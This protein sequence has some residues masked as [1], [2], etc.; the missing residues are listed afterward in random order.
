MSRKQKFA[1][2]EPLYLQL[3]GQ[4]GFAQ[5]LDRRVKIAV[6]L[7][8]PLDLPDEGGAFLGGEPLFIHG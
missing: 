8:E 4:P 1:L 5:R 3:V 7:A 2:L 6:L